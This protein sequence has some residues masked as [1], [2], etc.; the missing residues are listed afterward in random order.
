[1]K[2]IFLDVDGVLNSNTSKSCSP[3]G[4][5]GVS[6]KYVKRLKRIVNDTGAKVVLSSDWKMARDRDYTYLT[7]KLWFKGGIRIHSQTPNIEREKRGREIYEWLYAH[8]SIDEYII[9]D[10]E[11]F[12]DFFFY[13]ELIN[14]LLLINPE[15]GLT[16]DNVDD[17]I[18]FLNA[19]GDW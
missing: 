12:T 6:D 7:Q 3:N 18:A 5:L 8:P 13:D 9:I 1:M 15:V 17:A 2:V 11:V 4:Y 14:H 16:D 10:D 19:E